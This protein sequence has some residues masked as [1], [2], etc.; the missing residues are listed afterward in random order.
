MKVTHFFAFATFALTTSTTAL[1][2]SDVVE[3]GTRTHPSIVENHATAPDTFTNVVASGITKNIFGFK[4]ELEPT[5]EFH[6]RF[7][8][9]AEELY[10]RSL[11][12]KDIYTRSIARNSD[13]LAERGFASNAK[14]LLGGLL[15][16]KKR[17]EK[18]VTREVSEDLAGRSF[19]SKL[20]KIGKTIL[21][22]ILRRSTEETLAA[23]EFSDELV[24]RSFFSKLKKIG[25]TIL[26][27]ILRRSSELSTR[28][29]QAISSRMEESEELF[30]RYYDDELVERSE[31][32][33]YIR[34]YELEDEY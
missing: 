6:A 32:D 23:R 9:D 19:L 34:D 8:D 17:D 11:D 18:L 14:G 26:G 12:D 3:I 29:E 20:K 21:G 27:T 1:P 31:D 24:E 33:L 13:A 4:R 10:E 25:K 2:M 16:F 28:S 15:G 5:D 30:E 22:T 7:I